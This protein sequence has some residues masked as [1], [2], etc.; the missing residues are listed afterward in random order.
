VAR[1]GKIAA[2]FPLLASL[3]RGA[4]LPS[5]LGFARHFA[6]DG[7]SDKRETSAGERWKNVDLGKRLAAVN[8][9][10]GCIA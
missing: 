2:A 4:T 3:P 5:A 6:G 10:V 9:T 7:G 1:F 8:S